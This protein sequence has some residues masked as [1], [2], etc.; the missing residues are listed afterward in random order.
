M[1]TT[2]TKLT[3]RMD[4]DLVKR[5]KI[6]A[7]KSGKSVSA[8]VADYFEHLDSPLQAKGHRLTPAVKGLI[9]ILPTS[10]DEAAYRKHI[11]IKHK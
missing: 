8:I 2:Q 3:L 5:A 4:R 11:Q 10:A 1:P 9:G 7:G 6:Y